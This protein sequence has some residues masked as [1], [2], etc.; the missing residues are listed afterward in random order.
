VSRTCRTQPILRK[1]SLVLAFRAQKRLDFGATPVQNVDVLIRLRNAV[2][3][4]RP[5]WFDAK[6]EHQKLSK[7]MQY[8]FTASPFLPGELLF[9]RAWA[10]QSFAE[11]AV[12]STVS[13]L[14]YF[15]AEAKLK[16]P[17]EQFR[18]RL[19]SLSGYAL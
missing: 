14:D 11:W 1:Y 9:P 3:H 13:Y 5:E 18:D 12:R 10:S 2:V 7:R 16:N 8:R 4:F 15:Y 19:A 17:I 6:E